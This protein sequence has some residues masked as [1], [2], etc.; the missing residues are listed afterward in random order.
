MEAH[1]HGLP[2]IVSVQNPYS[3]LTRMYEVGNA[4]ISIREKCGLLAYSPL[5]FGILSGKYLNNQMPEGSR[6]Q[7]FSKQLGRYN[8]DHCTLATEKYQH[9]AQQ[10]DL[11]LT[12]LALGFVNTRPFLTSNIIGATTL[13]QLEENIATIDVDITPEIMMEIET[14]HKIHTYPAP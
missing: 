13:D 1:T 4:E 8:N 6:M 7:L 14:I 10:F 5:A 3:L 12:Q 2:K 9:I 11:S